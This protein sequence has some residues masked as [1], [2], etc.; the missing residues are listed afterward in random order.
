MAR[1]DQALSVSMVFVV[2]EPKTH[3]TSTGALSAAG[4]R[5]PWPTTRPDLLKLARAIEDALTGVVYRDD[6]LI[7]QE[8]LV[9]DYAR[10]GEAPHVR[11][12][13]LPM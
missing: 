10:D 11:I 3:R 5:Q 4:R 6:A 13:I 1:Y 12:I 2:A 8:R 9:K 7:V